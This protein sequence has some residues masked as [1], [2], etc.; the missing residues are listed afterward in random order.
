MISD[1]VLAMLMYSTTLSQSMIGLNTQHLVIIINYFKMSCL[2]QIVET[3]VLI[4]LTAKALTV[5]VFDN[6]IYKPP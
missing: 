2:V 4:T 3:L 5:S 1:Q 6:K